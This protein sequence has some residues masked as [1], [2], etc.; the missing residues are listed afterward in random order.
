VDSGGCGTNPV[1][2][3]RRDEQESF[4]FLSECRSRC[5]SRREGDTLSE[6]VNCA[7]DWLPLAALIEGRILAMHGGIG[8]HVEVSE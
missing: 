7:F 5:R 6:Q 2:A 3:A 1:G 8:K 4:G